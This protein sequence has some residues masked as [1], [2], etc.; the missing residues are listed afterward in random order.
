MKKDEKEEIVEEFSRKRS[1]MESI[2]SDL[3]VRG[4]HD[5]VAEEI[6]ELDPEFQRRDRWD[7]KRRSQLIES[8]LLNVPIPPIYLSHEPGAPYSVIDGKQ[9][10]TAMVLFMK[11]SLPLKG[12]KILTSLEG[13]TVDD[14]PSEVKRVLSVEPAIRA[15]I[16]KPTVGEGPS[17][18]SIE[19]KY[20]VFHRLNTGGIKLEPQ[21]LRNSVYRGPF[22]DLLTELAVNEYMQEQLKVRPKD[23]NYKKMQ[24]IEHVLRFLMMRENWRKTSKEIRP[25]M[26]DFMETHQHAGPDVLEQFRTH[27]LRMADRA[28]RLLGDGAFRRWIPNSQDW[29]DQQNLAIYDAQAIALDMLTDPE[30]ESILE[31]R[32]EVHSRLKDELFADPDFLN[33]IAKATGSI[34]AVV[35]RVTKMSEFFK[36]FA[37]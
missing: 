21:E 32:E 16:V 35:G 8:I 12:M 36:G 13:K 17:E 30:F 27:Y 28:E 7:D 15:V 22:N 25:M 23:K 5:W 6:I 31:R 1:R 4:V 24:D 10:I 26:D 2:A 14:L 19:L 33:Y 11:G 34:T 9:R 18:D 3:T 20:E 29:R 37:K